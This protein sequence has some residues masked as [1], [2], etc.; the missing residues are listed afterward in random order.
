M[1]AG[2]G[3][4]VLSEEKTEEVKSKTDPVRVM[5]AAINPGERSGIAYS[6]IY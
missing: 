5:D 4:M 1:K 3:N 6:F 2:M